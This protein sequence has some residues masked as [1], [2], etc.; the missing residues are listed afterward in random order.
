MENGF[1]RNS[2]ARNCKSISKNGLKVVFRDF[3]LHCRELVNGRT[4]THVDHSVFLVVV[5]GRE[6]E[7]G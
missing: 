2:W 6:L 4:Q 1:V 3:K 7:Q 5:G